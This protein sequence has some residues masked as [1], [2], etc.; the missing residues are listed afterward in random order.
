MSVQGCARVAQ[1]RLTFFLAIC[2]KIQQLFLDKRCDGLITVLLAGQGIYLCSSSSRVVFSYIQINHLAFLY[3]YD[4]HLTSMSFQRMVASF[5]QI[6]GISSLPVHA[7]RPHRCYQSSNLLPNF[8]FTTKL[9]TSAE[10]VRAAPIEQ[11]THHPDGSQSP[12][13]VL[14]IIIDC[15][16]QNTERV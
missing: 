3:Y 12:T 10:S 9:P 8:K 14:L 6:L 16:T 5:R 1:P 11:L 15:R 2:A 4:D 7:G 13:N